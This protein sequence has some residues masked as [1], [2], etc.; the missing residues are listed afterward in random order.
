MSPKILVVADGRSPTAR[1]WIAH[2]LKLDFEVS[3]VSTYRAEP[4]PGVRDSI[5]IPLALSRFQPGG[6][7]KEGQGPQAGT[8]GWLK[9]VVRRLSPLIL[10]L[11]YLVGPLS[12]RLAA[13]KYLAFLAQVQ[14]DLVH[15]L[16]I[17]YEGL[18]GRFT[19]EGIPFLVATWGNDLT[20]HASGSPWM[21]AATRRCLERADG[22]TSDTL[23][24]IR[25]AHEWGLRPDAPTLAVPGSGGLDLDA[26]DRISPA[27]FEPAKYGLPPSGPWVVNP[28]GLRPGSVHQDVFFA[29]IPKIL[30]QA[31]DTVFICPALAGVRQAEE[32]IRGWDIAD[33]TFLL[34]KLPQSELFALFK[35]SQVFVSPSSHDGTP[36]TLL[37]ALACGCTPVVGRI[38]S[39]EEW[40]TSG[41]NGEL[42]NPRDPNA[43]AKAVLTV[44]NSP[45]KRKQ[46]AEI[47]R[48]ILLARAADQ[49]TLPTIATFYKQFLPQK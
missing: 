18:L 7:T 46:A 20:L 30:A 45:E 22:L 5:V 32:W 14:P 35:R 47:N 43:L 33:R 36:N 48:E 38:E 26:I 42:V 17:P 3:L 23:R 8:S 39:L 11:R 24:D 13:G 15:A 44:L 29:A 21:K 12:A 2:L 6:S 27:E 1:S 34:P 31:P 28:R 4:V 37:E 19:P 49:A 41:K 9:K 10:K 16:R 25:L 40:I